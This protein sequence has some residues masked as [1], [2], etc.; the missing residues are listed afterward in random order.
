PLW[1]VPFIIAAL[2]VPT[3][4]GLAIALRQPR[5]V[6]AWILLVGAFAIVALTGP[7]II[8]SDG[9][10]LQ[11]GRATWP[12]LYAWPIAVTFVF[13]DGR[14]LS[15]RW[16]YVAVAGAVSFVGFMAMAMLDPTPFYG[17]DASVPNPMAGNAVGEWLDDSGVGLVWVVLWVGI[18]GSLVAGA[19]A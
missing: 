17:N 9:W 12:L 11:V 16:R 10:A 6:I 2:L 4:V 8:F 14:F 18:L 7:D 1:I 5:N 13:P 19:V 15:R 3:A